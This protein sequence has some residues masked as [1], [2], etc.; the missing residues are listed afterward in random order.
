VEDLGFRHVIEDVDDL[1]AGEGLVA[2]LRHVLHGYTFRICGFETGSHLRLIDFVHHSS[3]GLQVLNRKKKGVGLRVWGLGLRVEGVK[4][5]S[6]TKGNQHGQVSD[7]SSAVASKIM[8]PRSG[9]GKVRVARLDMSWFRAPSFID[10]GR[11]RV[12]GLWSRVQQKVLSQELEMSWLSFGYQG[13]SIR[14]VDPV[15]FRV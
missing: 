4:A 5:N 9:L 12:W 15:R 8:S 11:F 6:R 2:R 3:L 1:R 10:P 14:I 7:D 13:Y